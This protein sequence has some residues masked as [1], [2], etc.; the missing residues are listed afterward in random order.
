LIS[1]IP[2]IRLTFLAEPQL[3]FVDQIDLMQKTKTTPIS[4]P[5][6]PQNI[7]LRSELLSRRRKKKG[8]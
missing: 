2:P 8:M 4:T 7:V 3:A 5:G 1:I 6:M